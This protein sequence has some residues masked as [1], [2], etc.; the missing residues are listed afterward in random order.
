MG[1]F[2]YIVFRNWFLY[3]FMFVCVCMYVYI[4]IYGTV[5]IIGHNVLSATESSRPPNESAHVYHEFVV[6]TILR[7]IIAKLEESA[8]SF[9]AE[10]A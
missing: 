10:S 4:Y 5:S 6:W 7:Q 2:I 1:I 3:G 9:S 8:S